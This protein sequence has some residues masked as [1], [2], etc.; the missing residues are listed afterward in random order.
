MICSS[1]FESLLKPYIFSEEAMS[2]HPQSGSNHVSFN[3][4]FGIFSFKDK[5]KALTKLPTTL[6]DLGAHQRL[7]AI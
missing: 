3:N 7:L 2:N 4:Q 1:K 6:H 5:S